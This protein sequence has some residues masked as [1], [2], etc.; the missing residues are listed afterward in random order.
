MDKRNIHFLTLLV[1][2][3]L[4]ASVLAVPAQAFEI[5]PITW[6]DW[7]EVA[8]AY[9][10]AYPD[11]A[12]DE[13]MTV[14]YV[15][16]DG[17]YLYFRVEFAGDSIT[18]FKIDLERRLDLLIYLDVDQNQM[19]GDR[20][21]DSDWDSIPLHDI[22]AEW[23]LN[24]P[25]EFNTYNTGVEDAI[26]GIMASIYKWD[27]SHFVFSGYIIDYEIDPYYSYVNIRVLLSD[28][29]NPVFPI[30]ILFVTSLWVTGTDYNPDEG[31]ITYP[32]IPPRPPVGGEIAPLSTLIIL[33]PWIALAAVALTI[34]YTLTRRKS[35]LH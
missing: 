15:T 6:P 11:A 31:H 18:Q 13:D 8:T 9:P 27:G 7:E 34:G 2:L 25:I 17:Q 30:D 5:E 33:A 16:H 23:R 3:N 1:A 32:L 4:V 21:I 28:V 14:C 35:I 20:D 24:L 19:T 29:G 26:E 12:P 22:G 10:D